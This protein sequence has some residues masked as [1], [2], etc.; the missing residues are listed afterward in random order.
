[1]SPSAAAPPGTSPADE[2]TLEDM[3]RSPWA[4]VSRVVIVAMVLGIAVM[5]IFAF[6][7][8]HT[9]P[10]R[11]DDRTFP[12]AAEPVCAGAKR[13]VDGLPPAFETKDDR[14]RRA[15]VVDQ[16]T[17]LLEG[18]VAELRTLPA[19]SE[20]GARIDQWLADWDTYNRDRRD[21]TAR[22]RQDPDARF[23]MSQSDRDKGQITRALD[24]F[25]RVN[26]MGSCDAP[27][28]VV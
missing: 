21:Y 12:T 2:P 16:G 20:P 1:M 11:M 28:D 4:L 3:R 9:V 23:Y 6:F 24:N 13:A 10:G 7:G 15:D 18:M 26:G 27:E 14:Q 5:W 22:L 19:G 8:N 25:A 17:A